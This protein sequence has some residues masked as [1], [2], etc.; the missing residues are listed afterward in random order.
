MIHSLIWLF[1]T[2]VR[3]LCSDGLKWR[4]LVIS[5]FAHAQTLERCI[6]KRNYSRSLHANALMCMS[7]FYGT[8]VLICHSSHEFKSFA[9]ID[10]IQYIQSVQLHLG[11]P[12]KGI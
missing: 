1:I 12:Y 3:Q 11:S 8:R 2:G 4:H 6:S 7:V 5:T 10:N 9:R